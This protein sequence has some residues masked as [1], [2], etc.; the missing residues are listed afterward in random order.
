MGNQDLLSLIHFIKWNN[1]K[2]I[3]HN[4]CVKCLLL[5]LVI[6]CVPLCVCGC[7]CVGGV[8][9]FC[10]LLFVYLICQLDA[11][12][13][14]CRLLWWLFN[15]WLQ[16]SP[17]K[18]GPFTWRVHTLCDIRRKLKFCRFFFLSLSTWMFLFIK[19]GKYTFSNRSS[20]AMRINKPWLFFAFVFFLVI[21]SYIHST[22]YSG[23]IVGYFKWENF[24]Y[25][26]VKTVKRG[27]FFATLM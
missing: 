10:T 6:L 26:L 4:V 27:H 12:G 25:F 18:I 3:P 22:F 16:L 5:F 14:R 7:L 19:S 9:I 13:R 20:N 24:V 2:R 17:F 15:I 1:Q 8:A 11:D 23:V 21:R